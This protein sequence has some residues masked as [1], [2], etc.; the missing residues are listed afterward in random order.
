MS[1]DIVV[2]TVFDRR[3]LVKGLAMLRSLETETPQSLKFVILCLDD[4]T[5]EALSL[6]KISSWHLILLSDFG[7]AEVLALRSLREWREFCWTLAAA[8]LNFVIQ[9]SENGQIVAYVDADCYFF[10]DFTHITNQLSPTVEILIHEHRFSPD[11]VNWE[12]SSGRFNVGVIAGTVGEQFISCIS[13]WREQVIEECTLDPLNG[14]CGDQTYLNDWPEKYSRLRIL[15]SKGAGVGPWNMLNYQVKLDSRR[16]KIDEDDLIF[17]HFSRFKIVHINSW[18]ITYVS[19][20]GYK[21]PTIIEKLIYKEYAKGLISSARYAKS[22]NVLYWSRESL[23]FR[24]KVS[25]FKRNIVKSTFRS[26]DQE[27]RAAH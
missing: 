23:T 20:E 22:R 17:F 6:F 15:T 16:I 3:Y 27:T 21:V 2:C 19:A 10:N 18:H 11:R 8:L 5:Y 12:K 7:D 4:E 9:N 24:K 13:R 14:K 1:T 25:M 26:L